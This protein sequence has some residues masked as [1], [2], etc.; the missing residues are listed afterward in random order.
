MHNALASQVNETGVFFELLSKV[1]SAEPV[2]LFLDFVFFCQEV[3]GFSALTTPPPTPLTTTP[4]TLPPPPTTMTTPSTV[5]TTPP[6]RITS[7]ATTT[8]PR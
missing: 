3:L 5:T 8:T 2:N 1:K 6:L 4:R 7:T